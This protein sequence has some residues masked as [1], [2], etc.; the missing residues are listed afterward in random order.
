MKPTVNIPREKLAE[1][2]QASGSTLT[3]EEYTAALPGTGA[4][5]K[6][7]SR[8]RGR[9]WSK[10]I[11]IFVLIFPCSSRWPISASRISLSSSALAR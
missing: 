7:P 10:N 11:L 2:L 5:V 8:A 6:F 4:F 1:L 9:G 3:P